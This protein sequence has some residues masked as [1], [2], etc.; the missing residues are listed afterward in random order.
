MI[1]S[2]DFIATAKKIPGVKI[3][4][5][6]TKTATSQT[7]MASRIWTQAEPRK[8]AKTLS[9]FALPVLMVS[10]KKTM[11]P[12]ERIEETPVART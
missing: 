1:A 10:M 11:N 7:S 9:I 8:P 4:P 5:T 3:T 12:A 6:I 2:L